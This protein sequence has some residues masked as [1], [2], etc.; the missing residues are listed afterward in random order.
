MPLLVDT[1][2]LFALADRSDSW[3]ERTR[4]LVAS[5]H[6]SMLVPVTVLPE[7]AYLL[8]ERIGP[9]AERAFV[10][11]VADRELAIE[12]VRAHDWGRVEE[13][14]GEYVNSRLFN[15]IAWSLAIVMIVLSVPFV[16]HTVR[17]LGH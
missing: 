7:V 9:R 5:L 8:H 14:M 10:R 4:A 1:G 17:Q 3:H 2:V 16:W 15:V 13:L 11:S 12:D 6:D